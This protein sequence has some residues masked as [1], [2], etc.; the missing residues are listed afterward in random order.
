MP[1]TPNAPSLATAPIPPVLAR[2]SLLRK[3]GRGAIVLLGTIDILAA[4]PAH[5]AKPITLRVQ[6]EPA[7]IGLG[8]TATL[9]FEARGGLT[10]LDLRPSFSLDNLEIV[11][12]PS[13]AEEMRVENGRLSRAVRLSWQVRPI[14]VGP[15]RAQ[16]IH[17]ELSGRVVAMPT[18]SIQVQREPTG[19]GQDERGGSFGADD[20]FERLLG[21]APW[22]RRPP[23]QLDDPH[24]PPVAFI[25]AELSNEHPFVNEQVLYTIYLYSRIEVAT[26]NPLSV[27]ELRGFWNRDVP[28]PERLPTEIV[29][30]GNLRY[31]RVPLLRRILFPLRAGEHTF[32]PV[33]FQII[34]MQLEQSFFSPPFAR[35][36]ATDLATPPL[37]IAVRALPEGPLGFEGAVGPVAVSATLSPNELRVG[38]AAT[39]KVRLAGSGNLQ[40]LPAPELTLPAGL[41]AFPPHESG[42]SRLS[43]NRLRAERTWTYVVVPDRIGSYRLELPQVPYFDPAAANFA[44][45]TGPAL[46]LVA[47]PLPPPS[48][49]TRSATLGPR[50]PGVDAADGSAGRSALASARKVFQQSLVTTGVLPWVASASGLLALVAGFVWFKRAGPRG[51]DAARRFD[52]EL[53]SA[54]SEER[55]RRTA[56]RIES[57]W[58]H[59]LATR[60]QL[61]TT[62]P[63]SGWAAA[64]ADRGIALPLAANLGRIA[65]DLLFLR[66]APQLSN[67]EAL[68]AEIIDRSRRLARALAEERKTPN[69]RIPNRSH[70][71]P[72]A[73]DL[74][75]A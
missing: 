34:T 33:R 6:L 48:A 55:P 59:L 66:T 56:A 37:S 36:M 68:R 46:A 15:A 67:P 63:T 18:Q 5:A 29:T 2:R 8:E 31:G 70:N 16:S 17:V 73:Q 42:S 57:A 20:P 49:T 47:R 40:G 39:L 27:P 25:R 65:E 61:E 24:A 44:K 54:L 72:D 14:A 32:E 4:H 12:G 58:S 38:E 22:L 10:N 1:L 50:E 62:L 64:A 71:L 30:L 75:G 69:I 51:D 21:S 19:Q 9:S 52:A 11:T 3:A 35:P 45:A 60:W 53:R 26:I 41:R 23:P 74:R 28:L 43:G 7:R 13:Q